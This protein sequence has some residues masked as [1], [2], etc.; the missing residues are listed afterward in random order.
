VRWQLSTTT[1]GKRKFLWFKSKSRDDE[2]TKEVGAGE[3][4]AHITEAGGLGDKYKV[5]ETIYGENQGHEAWGRYQDN[6]VVARFFFDRV[7]QLMLD[8][9]KL[10]LPKTTGE[11]AFEF[12]KRYIPRDARLLKN[13]T[14]DQQ[15]VKAHF[16]VLESS[17]LKQVFDHDA[18]RD[19]DVE[20][21]TLILTEN[22]SGIYMLNV[23]LGEYK[24]NE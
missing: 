17:L 14:V 5:M 6:A 20:A 24:E 18:A 12:A 10:Q 2:A 15:E 4:P 1:N 22:E 11:E 9:D 16:Y 7:V 3:R 8:Y 21:F 19:L 13:W 23:I